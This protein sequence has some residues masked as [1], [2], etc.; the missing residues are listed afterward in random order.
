MRT[1][2]V[3]TAIMSILALLYLHTTIL[4]A[5]EYPIP[6][7]DKP[8]WQGLTSSAPAQAAGILHARAMTNVV[9]LVALTSRKTIDNHKAASLAYQNLFSNVRR[10]PAGPLYVVVVV[11]GPPN[12]FGEHAEYAYVFK[13]D[14]GKVGWEPRPVSEKELIAIECAVGHCP[15]FDRTPAL[16][17]TVSQPR[18]CVT[19]TR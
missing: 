14:S 16:G 3:L 4:A 1:N 15:I 8:D 5:N 6:F 2:K 17:T 18:Y 19:A 9:V 12:S 7:S 13:R 11:Y 10:V